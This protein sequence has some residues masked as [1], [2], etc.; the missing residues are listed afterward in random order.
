MILRFLAL[1][2]ILLSGCNNQLSKTNDDRIRLYIQSEPISLNPSLARDRRSQLVTRELFEGLTRLGQDGIT[3]NALAKSVDV[4]TDG[5]TLTFHLKTSTWSNGTPLTAYDFEWA[6]KRII[7]PSTGSPSAHSFFM[8]KNAKKAH[9]KECSL[10][11]VGV[12]AIN[13][14]TLQVTLEGQAPYFLEMIANPIYSPLCRAAI[15]RDNAWASSEGSRFVC[16]GPFF[17]KKH[18]IN[19]EI[20]L[21][22]NP[23]YWDADNVPTKEF[24]FTIV[25]DPQTAYNM[26]KDGILDWYGDPCGWMSLEVIGDLKKENSLIAKTAGTVSWLYCH[27]STP[28]LASPKIRKAL[29]HAINRK[30]LCEKLLQCHESPAFS[31]LPPTMSG[32]V[33]PSF[34]DNRPDIANQLFAEGLSELGL[35]PTT[36]PPIVLSYWSDPSVKAL[37]SAVQQQLEKALPIHI[38]LQPVDWCTWTKKFS[39]GDFQLLCA[40]W[41]SSYNDP[42]CTMQWYRKH[43]GTAWQCPEFQKLLDLSDISHSIS[44]RKAYLNRA[45]ALFLEELPTIPLVYTTLKYAK[46]KRIK[47]EVFSET[48]D[49]ELTWLERTNKS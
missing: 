14:K 6:W 36:F 48:G 35:T 31:I 33:N 22:K 25:E 40:F 38:E 45:E 39:T 23:L 3:K 15:E 5:L 29:A 18:V 16:N 42:I 13:D 47:G 26:F 7:D 27:V 4:S 1:F 24:S 20:I 21:E 2:I 12:V 44:D 17:L 43:H 32:I 10:D 41:F 37:M 30:E 9:S 46:G 34:L 19:S 49:V 11:E 28:H 8:I